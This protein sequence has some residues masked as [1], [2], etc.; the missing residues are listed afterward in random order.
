MDTE[1]YAE[2]D[3]PVN[4]PPEVTQS[5]IDSLVDFSISQKLRK[6]LEKLSQENRDDAKSILI[7][8]IA[9]TEDRIAQRTTKGTSAIGG[10]FFNG[11]LKK[12]E[13]L[14]SQIKRGEVKPMGEVG[15][16]SALHLALGSLDEKIRKY[17]QKV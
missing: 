10:E 16:D 8:R 5:N 1:P 13:A 2:K 4:W 6:E 17:N 12:Q 3:K 9:I 11:F 7:S 14:K 15:D